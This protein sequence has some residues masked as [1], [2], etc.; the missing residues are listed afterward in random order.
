VVYYAARFGHK[1]TIWCS[2]KAPYSDDHEAR[3]ADERDIKI[4]TKRSVKFR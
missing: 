1:R 4:S 2:W 3:F